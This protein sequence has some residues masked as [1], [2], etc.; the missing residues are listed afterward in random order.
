[1]TDLQLEK[2]DQADGTVRI[3]DV[4]LMTPSL[5]EDYWTYRVMLGERQA[6][7]GFP[8]FVTIGIGFAVEDDDW[9]TNLPYTCDAVEIFEHIKVNRGDDAISDE[10]CVAA[11]RL[12]QEAA[13][14]D[15]EMQS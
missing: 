13:R 7:V 11:I 10:D 1:M 9:N 4:G 3:G 12:I 8:K 15:R 2:R 14:A 6:I 5:G